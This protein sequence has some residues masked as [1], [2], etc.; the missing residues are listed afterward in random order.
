MPG[1]ITASGGKLH[2][3]VGD[4]P[5]V[6]LFLV[7]GGMFLC[8]FAIHY[9]RSDVKFPTDPIKAVLQGKGIPA[10]T[11]TPTAAESA[12]T[13][14]ASSAAT[15]TSA[16]AG[17]STSGPAVVGTSATGTMIANDALRYNGQG[18]VWGGNGSRPGNWDCSSFVSYVLGH[19]LGIPI[20]GGSWA[21]AT[22]NGRQH[23]PTT[24]QYL[25]YGSSISQGQ[26]QAGDLIVSSEHI[27]IAINSTQMISA[28]DEKSGTGIAGFPGGFPAGPPVYRRVA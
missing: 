18:Y 2:T 1:D 7:G 9:W 19:D 8:W 10:S 24:L 21:Q 20:P 15:T 27:G 14:A 4:A 17:L 23:G 22:N 28:E 5:I 6:P 16:A 13:A 26:V 12:V 11:R 25:T 3:P